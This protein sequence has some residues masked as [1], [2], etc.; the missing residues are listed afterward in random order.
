MVRCADVEMTVMKE[1][2][3]IL[4]FLEFKIEGMA[5]C[6]RGLIGEALGSL[7]RQRE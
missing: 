5:C 4:S 3:V 7:R 2:V 6:A 1:E